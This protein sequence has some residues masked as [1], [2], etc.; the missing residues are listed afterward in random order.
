MV[1]HYTNIYNY[2]VFPY[3]KACI[4]RF[5]GRKSCANGDSVT[6]EF[7]ITSAVGDLSS[8]VYIFISLRSLLTVNNDCG[9][10]LCICTHFGELLLTMCR[11]YVYE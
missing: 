6:L 7:M 2:V 4:F 9:V 3:K 8:F 1:M 11:P 10:R 5:K